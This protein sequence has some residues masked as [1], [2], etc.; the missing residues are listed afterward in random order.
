M[1]E[2]K[3]VGQHQRLNGLE[4]EQIPEDSEGQGTLACYNLWDLKESD[5]TQRPNNNI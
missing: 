1:A 3:M 2:D 5:I 4:F